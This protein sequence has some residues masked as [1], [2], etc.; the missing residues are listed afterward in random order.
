MNRTSTSRFYVCKVSG[1]HPNYITERIFLTSTIKPLVPYGVLHWTFF[2][3]LA[4]TITFNQIWLSN[5]QGRVPFLPFIAS[6]LIGRWSG[7][8]SSSIYLPR[9]IITFS[10]VGVY[11][12]SIIVSKVVVPTWRFCLAK[13]NKK[14]ILKSKTCNRLWLWVTILTFKTKK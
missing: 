6:W 7:A 12:T 10:T 3:S 8:Y 11:I 4:P 14:P 9:S 5:Q 13:Q 1:N 2:S